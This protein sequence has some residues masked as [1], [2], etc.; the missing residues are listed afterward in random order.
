MRIAISLVEGLNN[1]NTKVWGYTKAQ[2]LLKNITI[3]LTTK[4]EI[5]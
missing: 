2:L 4:Y 5:C 1:A 3:K